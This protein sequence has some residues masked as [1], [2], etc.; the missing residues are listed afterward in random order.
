MNSPQGLDAVLSREDSI[1]GIFRNLQSRNVMMKS[2]ILR[3]MAGLSLISRE[4]H[5]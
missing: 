5:Q 1:R 3:L 4:G 2:A